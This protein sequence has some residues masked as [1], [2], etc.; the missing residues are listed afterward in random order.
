MSFL[1]DLVHGNTG[2]LGNDI[3]HDPWGTAG[4]IGGGIAASVALPFLAPEI[5]TFLGGLGADAAGAGGAEALSGVGAEALGAGAGATE[6]A[7]GFAGDA[8]ATGGAAAGAATD[9]TSTALGLA[10]TAAAP[11]TATT[12][13]ANAAGSG[14][15]P[16]A[17]LDPL[18]FLYDQPAAAGGTPSG[19]PTSGGVGNIAS[20]YNGA[21]ALTSGGG[22]TGGATGGSTPAAASGSKS[23][24]DT[25]GT[26]ISNIP[27]QIASNPLSIAAP[28]VGAAGL[29]YALYNQKNN[30]AGGAAQNQLNAVAPGQ[31]SQGQGLQ[32]YLANGTLPPGAQAQVDQQI[33][34]A[35]AQAI[36][37]AAKQG[38][39]TD[40]SQNSALAAQFAQIESSA[41]QQQQQLASN[42]FNQ[43]S[44]EVGVGT[45]VL[46]NIMQV[47]QQQTAQTG[48]AIS[49]FASSLAGLSGVKPKT[50]PTYATG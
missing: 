41:V 22:A 49:S 24:L 39:P 3:S 12:A 42:L 15:D 46:N 14:F 43:G 1:T 28:L 11:T 5:G 18:K 21:D 32:Q 36:S 31:I 16:S 37:A 48:Q 9:A 44:A 20:S 26:G 2:N 34:A 25:L 27:N 17:G 19:L 47:N 45:G 40:P 6:A 7:L 10:P 35:K 8:G 13:V 29:G 23:F 30:P 4:A 50:Q 38:L 33:K